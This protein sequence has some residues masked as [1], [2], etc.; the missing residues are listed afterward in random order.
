M[1]L[2][3]MGWSFCCM[4]RGQPFLYGRC[5]GSSASGKG[6]QLDSVAGRSPTES[7]RRLTVGWRQYADHTSVRFDEL[8]ST[9]CGSVLAAVASVA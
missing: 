1:R 5:L 4:C 9:L 7:W 8:R 2:M 6:R 3:C